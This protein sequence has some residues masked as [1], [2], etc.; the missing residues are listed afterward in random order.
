MRGVKSR[1]VERIQTTAKC[2]T[3]G[4]TRPGETTIERR[5]WASGDRRYHFCDL[6]SAALMATPIRPLEDVILGLEG[7]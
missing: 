5:P 2:R 6:C 7:D 4:L 3:C 1:T